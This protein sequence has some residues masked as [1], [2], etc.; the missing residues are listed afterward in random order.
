MKYHNFPNVKLLLQLG[1]CHDAGRNTELRFKRYRALLMWQKFPRVAE[2]WSESPLISIVTS[3]SNGVSVCLLHR[4][5]SYL[6]HGVWE[7]RHR[8][9]RHTDTQRDQPDRKREEGSLFKQ[10][11]YSD[12]QKHHNRATE[13]CRAW[14]DQTARSVWCGPAVRPL[15][16]SW[17]SVVVSRAIL[18]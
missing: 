13:I 17:V 4:K 9:D 1:S 10:H 16:G 6:T 8:I 5:L 3:S 12:H 11:Q 15:P 14:T 2:Q 18:N 7:S